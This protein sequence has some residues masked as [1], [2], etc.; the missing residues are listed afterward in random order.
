MTRRSMSLAATLTLA[1]AV[2]ATGGCGDD[3]AA[4]LP[5]CAAGEVTLQGPACRDRQ[6]C[7]GALGCVGPNDSYSGR[8]CGPGQCSPNG[9]DG[10][11]AANEYCPFRCGTCQA[12]GKRCDSDGVTCPANFDCAPSADD[13]DEN[14]CARRACTSDADCD[15]GACVNGRCQDGLGSCLLSPP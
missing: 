1:L 8:A 12:M 10:T 11:C 13:R 5:T 15:C 9:S 6:G 4:K 14:G 3:E 7:S 2:L